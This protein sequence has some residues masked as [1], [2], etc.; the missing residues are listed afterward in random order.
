M[1]LLSKL[2][3]DGRDY[4]YATDDQLMEWIEAELRES[5]KETMYIVGGP[6]HEHA[7]Q[8]VE[9]IR[10]TLDQV[11]EMLAEVERRAENRDRS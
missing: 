9:R 8:R 6:D 4:D 5:A 2:F 1:K 10:E 3:D 11:D 7:K